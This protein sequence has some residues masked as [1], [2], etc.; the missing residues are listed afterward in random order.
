MPSLDFVLPDPALIALA[1][2]GI[3]AHKAGNAARD[4]FAGS[5]MAPA[6]CMATGHGV[7]RPTAQLTTVP[8]QLRRAAA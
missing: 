7:E 1:R 4:R 2:Q 3:R 8:S 5:M 6:A